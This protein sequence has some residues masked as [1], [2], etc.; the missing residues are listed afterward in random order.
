M[1]FSSQ[2]KTELCTVNLKS[3]HC[4]RAELA[5]I[6]YMSGSLTLASGG[7]SLICATEHSEVVTRLFSLVRHLYE[8]ECGLTLKNGQLKKSDTYL[9]TIAEGREASLDLLSNL[10]LILS[11]GI[12]VDDASFGSII[13]LACCKISF[14]RGAFLGS[15]TL[16]DPHKAYHL[17]FVATREDMAQ[18]LV[19]LLRGKKIEAKCISRKESWIVYLKESAQ[20]ITLLTLI[21][22]HSS[23]LELENIRILKEIRGNVNRQINCESANIDRTVRS[24]V[25][26]AENIRLIEQYLGLDKLSFPLRETAELRLSYPEASL[27]ELATLSN[28]NATRS[29]INHRLRKLNQIAAQLSYEHTR[30]HEK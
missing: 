27:S 19:S 21:G 12:G 2:V 1:S 4:M 8:R 10:G 23:I 28:G 7:M 11:G 26:Q 5:G 13:Q 18:R 16:S 14:I 25:E 29:G 15:G 24:G 22:A 9:V 30:S 6:V 3:A 20:I 17:E